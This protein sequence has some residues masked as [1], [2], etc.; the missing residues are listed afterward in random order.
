MSPI[1]HHDLARVQQSQ[2]RLLAFIEPLDT[3]G[4]RRLS[5]LPGWTVGHVLSHLARNA[6]SHRRRAEAAAQGQ[7]IDQYPGGAAGRSAEIEA[8]AGRSAAALVD[9]VRQSAQQMDEAWQRVP[10]TAWGNVTRDVNG[11]VR[12]L[13]DLPA[14]R[15]Q[16]LEVHLVD[17]DLGAGFESW[18]DDF[19]ATFLPPWRA[20]MSERLDGQRGPAAGALDGRE[21]LAWLLGRLHRADLPELT[22]W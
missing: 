9:D 22:P 11:T 21:E 6:D 8:G 14:R 7:V 15:W 5:R 10:E 17:L 2:A 12:P 20:T 4:M 18:S 19:V 1:P 16:E 3:A 13:S